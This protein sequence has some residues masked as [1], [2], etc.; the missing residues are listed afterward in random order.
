MCFI[1][2]LSFRKDSSEKLAQLH[3][4]VPFKG[5]VDLISKYKTLCLK[6]FLFRYGSYSKLCSEINVMTWKHT[7]YF[8]IIKSSF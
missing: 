6:H 7:F 1:V 4:N 8:N 5:T 3:T 2:K